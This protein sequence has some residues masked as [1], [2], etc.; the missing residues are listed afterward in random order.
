MFHPFRQVPSKRRNNSSS[1]SPERP[2]SNSRAPSPLNLFVNKKD[3]SEVPHTPLIDDCDSSID[4]SIYTTESKSTVQYVGNNGCCFNLNWQAQSSAQQASSTKL[5]EA[6]VRLWMSAGNPL[7]T[8]NSSPSTAP[9]TPDVS[10]PKKSR[11]YSFQEEQKHDEYAGPVD[12]DDSVAD[13]SSLDDNS[14]VRSPQGM[15]SSALYDHKTRL[16]DAT[17]ST[18]NAATMSTP[19]VV[20]P[21]LVSPDEDDED[22]QHSPFVWTDED[23]EQ[24]DYHGAERKLSEEEA[25]IIDQSYHQT[26]KSLSMRSLSA[27]PNSHCEEE[28]YRFDDNERGSVLLT[29]KELEKHI[30]KVQNQEPLPSSC[31]RG[32]DKWKER[33]EDQRRYF[34]RLQKKTQEKERHRRN[35]DTQSQDL[36][37]SSPILSPQRSEKYKLYDDVTLVTQGQMDQSIAS[38]IP[39]VTDESSFKRQKQSHSSKKQ[40]IESS[41]RCRWKLFPKFRSKKT[42]ASPAAPK[43]K[44]KEPTVVSLNQFMR[45]SEDEPSEVGDFSLAPLNKIESLTLASIFQEGNNT[46]AATKSRHLESDDGDIG[47]KERAK[48]YLDKERQ[49]QLQAELDKEKFEKM[50]Q[51]RIQRL[52]EEEL[53]RQRELN[54]LPPIKSLPRARSYSPQRYSPR[55]KRTNSDPHPLQ[56]GQ[57]V[58]FSSSAVS[59]IRTGST[60][61]L[62]PCIVCDSAERT[63]VAMPCMHFYFC[64][65]CVETMNAFENP[66]CPVCSCENVAFTRVYTG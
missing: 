37:A 46:L 18:K 34:D 40:G 66:I 45:I 55:C 38:T 2:K 12:L 61:T 44:S 28:H 60:I 36:S 47:L 10:P 50:E 25:A 62:S 3:S 58:S 11:R 17:C 9:S 52:K 57:S 43:K 4:M 51:E 15:A 35:H 65:S 23:D 21:P 26:M 64:K 14:W 24:R 30:I 33:K 27:H 31:I 41:P 53:K 22:D 5:K 56:V 39:T 6:G 20:S 49:K 8:T 48:L 16:I 42:I 19:V 7:A 59:S 32:Y 1:K 63:H 29:Q 13:D 54:M